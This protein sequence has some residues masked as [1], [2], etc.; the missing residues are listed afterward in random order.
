MLVKATWLLGPWARSSDRLDVEVIKLW[1]LASSIPVTNSFSK[2]LHKVSPNL[3]CRGS[4]HHSSP[5]P[6]PRL[7]SALLRVTL[8]GRQHLSEALPHQPSRPISLPHLSQRAVRCLQSWKTWPDIL[9]GTSPRG[10]CIASEE[11][12]NIELKPRVL[13]CG[14]AEVPLCWDV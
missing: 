2:T 5:N 1:H 11:C 6:T 3:L 12:P 13:Y 7:A 9:R 8:R 4:S 14:D 10:T